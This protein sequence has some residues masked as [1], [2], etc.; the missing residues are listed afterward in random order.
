M[1]IT[2]QCYQTIAENIKNTFTNQ[3]EKSLEKTIGATE[4]Q[5]TSLGLDFYLKLWYDVSN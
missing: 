4:T 2:N 1:I 5:L 3:R